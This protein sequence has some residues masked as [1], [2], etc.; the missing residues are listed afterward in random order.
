MEMNYEVCCC[1]YYQEKVDGH[2][3]EKNCVCWKKELQKMIVRMDLV[4]DQ[5][6]N[7]SDELEEEKV[8][9]KQILRP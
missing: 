8:E 2:R 4:Q 3:Q 1:H 6:L 5:N 9:E 7:G